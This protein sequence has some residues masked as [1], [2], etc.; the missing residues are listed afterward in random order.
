MALFRWVTGVWCKPRTVKN[1]LI[2]RGG[3]EFA[4]K[5]DGHKKC[6]NEK[7]NFVLWLTW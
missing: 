4:G 2:A 6:V 5:K 1:S 3:H 7:V